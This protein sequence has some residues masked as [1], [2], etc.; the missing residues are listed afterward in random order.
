MSAKGNWLELVIICALFVL[1]SVWGIV[2]DF[3]SGL[4][5]SGIDGIML[6]S[7]CLMM[8]LIFAAMLLFQLQKGGILPAFAPKTKTAAG[9]AAPAVASKPAAAPVATP[10]K[11]PS[12]APQPTPQTK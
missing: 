9:P 12:P 1:L 6:L 8:T 2:W 10:P 4:L 7:V 5:M 11:P 3:T